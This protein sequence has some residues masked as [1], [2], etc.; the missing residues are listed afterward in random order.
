MKFIAPRFPIYEYMLL[1]ENRRAANGSRRGHAPVRARMR[2]T[3]Q[4]L[5]PS[6][7]TFWD[8][9]REESRGPGDFEYDDEDCFSAGRG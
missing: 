3:L 1:A 2:C 4:I 8:G 9:V 6:E 5:V 7:A